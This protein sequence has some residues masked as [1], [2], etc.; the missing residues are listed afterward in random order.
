MGESHT[1]AV[2][3]LLHLLHIYNLPNKEDSLVYI[4]PK[5]FDFDITAYFENNAVIEA[6]YFKF[7]M[8]N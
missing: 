8:K 5:S 6:V 4:F 7:I 2:N 3:L 1:C